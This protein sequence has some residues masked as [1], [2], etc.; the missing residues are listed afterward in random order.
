MEALVF[1]ELLFIASICDYLYIKYR[2]GSMPKGWPISED[3]KQ[4]KA[5]KLKE[6]KKIILVT[7]ILNIITHCLV[8]WHGGRLS[9]LSFII[10]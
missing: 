10:L 6:A 9:F 5:Y 3:Q 7:T 2:R 1:F 4:W 8:Y